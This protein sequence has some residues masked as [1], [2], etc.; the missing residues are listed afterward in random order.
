VEEKELMQKLKILIEKFVSESVPLQISTLYA[1][2]VFCHDQ[3]FPK[4]RH[5]HS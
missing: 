5:A 3:R 4:G 2:Q 1:T